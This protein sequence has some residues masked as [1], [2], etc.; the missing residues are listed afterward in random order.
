M[1]NWKEGA[2]KHPKGGRGRK[3]TD[4]KENSSAEKKEKQTTEKR[5]KSSEGT[6]KSPAEKRHKSPAER[7]EES[8]AAGKSPRRRN[9]KSER[10]WSKVGTVQRAISELKDRAEGD[11]HAENL[12]AG[13]DQQDTPTSELGESESQETETEPKQTEAESQ[14]SEAAKTET[15][16]AG[17]APASATGGQAKKVR[18]KHL[19]LLRTKPTKWHVRAVKTQISLDIR[20]VWSESSLSAWRK[21]GSLA[22]HWAP[23]L[24]WVFAGRSHFVGFIN[25]WPKFSY[26]PNLCLVDSSIYRMS[27]LGLQFDKLQRSHFMDCWVLM[28]QSHCAALICSR[29][30]ISS[31]L[32]Q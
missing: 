10:R 4:K 29:N 28:G 15:K 16:E 12:D 24:I 13:N 20:P 5:E 1:T 21:L 32:L 25:R 9:S 18:Q 8:P 17:A 31:T 14:Q 30:P 11:V 27:D 19:S 7:R 6:D 26:T 2:P 23:R 3:K 22:T